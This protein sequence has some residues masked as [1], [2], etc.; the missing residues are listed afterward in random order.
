[1]ELQRIFLCFGKIV[2]GQ[3]DGFVVDQQLPCRFSRILPF[4][5]QVTLAEL[6]CLSGSYNSGVY[7]TYP[8]DIVFNGRSHIIPDS[9]LK[10]GNRHLTAYP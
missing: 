4:N 5:A 8:P 3:G 6:R 10:Q 7:R 2:K 1:M 9:R